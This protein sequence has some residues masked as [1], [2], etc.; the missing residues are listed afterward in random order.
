MKIKLFG[1]IHFKVFLRRKDASS[2]NPKPRPAKL[3]WGLAKEQSWAREEK[4]NPFSSSTASIE[5][6]FTKFHPG[7]NK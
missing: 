6:I 5:G 2:E 4:S 3:S 7:L 1:S